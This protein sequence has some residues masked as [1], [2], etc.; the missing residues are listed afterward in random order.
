MEQLN[1]ILFN[2]FTYSISQLL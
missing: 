2:I 1:E